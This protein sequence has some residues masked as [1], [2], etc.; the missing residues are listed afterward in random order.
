MISALVFC[1]YG[2]I[3]WYDVH[4]SLGLHL[5]G[6]L[7]L[8]SS[9]PHPQPPAPASESKWWS[10]CESATIVQG[11]VIEVRQKV[12]LIDLPCRCSGART[13]CCWKHLDNKTYKK[14]GQ[15]QV[16]DIRISSL[17]TFKG[18]ILFIFIV[19][20]INIQ[21]L[22]IISGYFGYNC[23]IFKGTFSP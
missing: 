16:D 17:Y 9:P 13:N 8:L 3:I 12:I 7:I 18:Y 2:A 21:D 22:K 5:L 15:T 19:L 23:A 6:C 4:L 14:T 10:E 1:N 11:F 20:H